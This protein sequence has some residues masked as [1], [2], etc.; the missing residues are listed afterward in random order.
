MEKYLLL[1]EISKSSPAHCFS[2]ARFNKFKLSG[3]EWENFG[4]NHA[5]DF[6]SSKVAPIM[7]FSF[8]AADEFLN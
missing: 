2:I 1:R 4:L 3:S 6:M 7:Y 5:V 8:I